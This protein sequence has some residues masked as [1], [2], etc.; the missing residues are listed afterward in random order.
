MALQ[1]IGRGMLNTG[2]SDSSDATAITI[3]S[4]ENSTFAGNI[5]KGNLTISGTEIDLSSGDLTLDVAGDII[6]DAGGQQIIF[7]TAGTNVGQIDMQGTDLEIKSLVN[8]ADLFIRGTDGGS[9]ITALTFD[10]SD[11]GKATFNSD[12]VFGGTGT[13]TSATN[14]LKALNTGDNGF[15]IRSA[16]SSAANPSY[17]NVDDTNTGM[18]LPGSDVIGLTTGGSERMRID[19]SGKVGIATTT[20]HAGSAL[21]Y[22]LTIDSEGAS[23]SI[24]EAHRTGNSRLEIYQFATGGNYIDSLGTTAFT[25]FATGGTERMR[26]DASGAVVV[27]NAGG[28]AQIYLG[29]TSGTSRMY[30]A[31]SGADSLLWNVSNGNLKF[32]TNNTERMRITSTGN[33]IFKKGIPIEAESGR[34]TSLS[35]PATF[36]NAL[37]FN[38]LGGT[39]ASRGFYLVTAVRSGGSVGTSYVALIGVSTSSASYIYNV[40][41]SNGFVG[42]MSGS[43]LQ[44]KNPSGAVNAHITAIPIGITGTD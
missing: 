8:N 27:N 11:G 32:G 29:G 3:D 44:L 5:V 17:S 9:E 24:L 15:L 19:S 37:N 40:I 34:V 23:G 13:I 30:L 12:I 42:Q 2:V 35:I 10:M 21:G 36:V 22:M 14:S 1:K 6:L 31:R 26:I 33:V 43:W 20:N 25:A 18:F 41:Y 7:A 39:D 38:T 16:V 28:D 4:S